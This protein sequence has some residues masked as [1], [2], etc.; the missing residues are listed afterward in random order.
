LL[1]VVV[2]PRASLTL[3][4]DESLRRFP[5]ADRFDSS[6]DQGRLLADLDLQRFAV[7]P[8]REPA[9]GD[10][11]TNAAMVYAKEA[12]PHFANPR[13]LAVEIAACFC[14]GTD[15]ELISCYED[16]VQST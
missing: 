2:L 12:R 15:V 7:E 13:Q 1:R 16:Y 8:P 14:I 3:V 9:H 10:L 4:S 5:R 6:P 11:S